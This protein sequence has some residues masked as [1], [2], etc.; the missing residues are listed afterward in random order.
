MTNKED[1]KD[2]N[3]ATDA[4]KHWEKT[5]WKRDELDV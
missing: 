1:V 3:G 4:G 2:I 5:A